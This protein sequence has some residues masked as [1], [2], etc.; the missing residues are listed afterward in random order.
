LAEAVT[1]RDQKVVG[2][3]AAI[4]PQ[5]LA[6]VARNLGEAH[7]Q[8]DLLAALHAHQIGHGSFAPGV[9]FG[10]HARPLEPGRARDRAAQHDRGVERADLDVLIGHQLEE[11]RLEAV[12]VVGDDQVR[13]RDQGAVAA[14]DGQAGGAH[15]L[16]EHIDRPVGQRQ[17]VGNFGV[18]HQKVGERHVQPQDLR[19]V[20]RYHKLARMLALVAYRYNATLSGCRPRKQH[21]HGNDQDKDCRGGTETVGQIPFHNSI[22]PRLLSTTRRIA[23]KN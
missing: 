2:Q 19:L 21:H 8:H 1:P 5:F 15:R 10:D 16:A 17:N 20:E 22:S 3:E 11:P 12:D 23:Q 7:R 9:L 14:I 18:A 13:H 4:D 6:G